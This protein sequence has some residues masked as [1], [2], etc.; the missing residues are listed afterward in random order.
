VIQL[1]VLDFDGVIVESAGLKEDAF[2]RLFP[3]HPDQHAAIRQYHLRHSGISRHVKLRHISESLL[4]RPPDEAEDTRLAERF[5]D[6]VESQVVSAD[7]VP[8]AREFI[9]AAINHYRLYVAS[10][11]PQDELRRITARRGI[12]RYFTGI[13]GSPEDKPSLL[14]RIAAVERVPL[15]AM[16]MVGDGATDRDAADEVGVRFVART[17][18][19]GPLADCEWQIRD[20]RALGPMLESFAAS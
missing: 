13:Y 9:E 11:T 15:S 20:L 6:I 10:G 18:A 4:G 5:R 14:R 19:D 12:A 1:V 3:D 2:V 16:V 8:G 7:F 17:A